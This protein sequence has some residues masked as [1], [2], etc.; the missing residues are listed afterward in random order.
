[1]GVLLSDF[2]SLDFLVVL[3]FTSDG[4]GLRDRPLVV[5][6]LDFLFRFAFRRRQAGNDTG[7]ALA[8]HAALVVHGAIPCTRIQTRRRFVRP[9]DCDLAVTLVPP[10]NHD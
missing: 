9:S 5:L 4:S 6:T 10:L 1:L 8:P 7:S 2:V 3:V